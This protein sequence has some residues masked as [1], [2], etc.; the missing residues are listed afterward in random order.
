[1]ANMKKLIAAAFLTTSSIGIA[2]PVATAQGT[3]VVVVNQGK[4]L[5]DSR[6]GKDMQ[7]KLN[8]I[9]DQIRNELQ[10]TQRS[11][12]AERKSLIERSNGKTQEAIR[13]DTA[14][15]GQWESFAKK[16]EDFN[17]ATQL[18]Q[19]E[20]ARTERKARNEFITAVN[21]VLVEVRT[22]KGA[23]LMLPRSS[24]I[25]ADDSVDVTQ[26]VISKLDSRKPTVNV[27]RQRCNFK[28][29]TQN[30]QTGEVVD[31]Q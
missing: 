9:A 2:A 6:A 14:L 8:S 28:T 1:M 27:V 31:C 26:S 12:A 23:Q 21:P 13:A 5:K 30:G 20:L 7:T 4:I 24:A 29:V 11:L 19:Q 10:T 25:G 16:A 3:K 18:R 15:L 22:E 17:R